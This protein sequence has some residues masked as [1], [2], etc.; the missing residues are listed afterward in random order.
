[1][2]GFHAD[3]AGGELCLQEDEIEDARWFA[4]DQLPTLPAPRSIARFLIEHYLA[5]RLGHT[6][7]RLD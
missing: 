6:L 2:L 7:P 1:M 5:Q 3:Y 4:I